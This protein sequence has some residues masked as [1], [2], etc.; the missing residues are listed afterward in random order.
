MLSVGQK[1]KVWCRQPHT[2]EDKRCYWT[3]RPIAFHRTDSD[4]KQLP[5]HSSCYVV[6]SLSMQKQQRVQQRQQTVPL[7]TRIESYADSRYCL[8]TQNVVEFN[9]LPDHIRARAS[10]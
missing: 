5:L 4:M 2:S 9:R 1:I 3:H 10:N 8:P 7:Y 6:D